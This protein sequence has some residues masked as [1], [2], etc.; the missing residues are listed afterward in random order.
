[1]K[2][3]FSI[4]SLS[5][6]VS[7]F[8]FAQNDVIDKRTS[9]FNLQKGVAIKGYDPIAF[10]NTN[11]ATQAN[12]SIT[13]EYNGVKYFFTS[14]KNLDQF[15]STPSKFEPQYGGWCAFHM[16][17]NGARVEANPQHF[18]THNG[19]LYF[20][21]SADDKYKWEEKSMETEGNM[22]WNSIMD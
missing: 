21:A 15:K 3:L 17:V 12:G 9:N 7:T 1:M 13:H 10:F 20:F 19:K 8:S 16:S 4:I 5:I 18:T 11:K 14:T 22:N 6:L 2:S